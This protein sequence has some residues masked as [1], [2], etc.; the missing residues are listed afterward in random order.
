MM[1]GS[2]F[3][4][5]AVVGTP[6]ALEVCEEASVSPS[7]LI[8][9]HVSGDWSELDAHDRREN[10]RAVAEGFRVFSAF[11]LENGQKLWVITEA[12][13][14]STCLLRPSEY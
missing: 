14:S 7:E 11:T 9:R 13:R 8:W 1:S 12:D 4:L 2:L 10:Q 5:G 3:A 6:G